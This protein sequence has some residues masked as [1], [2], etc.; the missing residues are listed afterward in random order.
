MDRKRVCHT[1]FKDG[2]FDDTYPCLTGY[3][4]FHDV[5]YIAIEWFADTPEISNA[6]LCKSSILYIILLFTNLNEELRS[7]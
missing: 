6:V 5:V 2:H 4:C 3:T 1:R 7:F